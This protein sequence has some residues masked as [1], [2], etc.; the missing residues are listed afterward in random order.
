MPAVERLTFLVPYENKIRGA[1]VN[2]PDRAKRQ[3]TSQSFQNYPA[4]SGENTTVAITRLE[5]GQ[6]PRP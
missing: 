6:E 4:H 3:V 2:G 1:A 5:Q